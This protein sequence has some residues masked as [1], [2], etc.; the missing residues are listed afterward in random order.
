MKTLGKT[1]HYIH[2]VILKYS[3]QKQHFLALF[4]HFVLFKFILCILI[5]IFLFFIFNY[6]N[7]SRKLLYYEQFI[8]IIKT[9]FKPLN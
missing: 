3:T 8:S 5:N 6:Y 7:R 9:I 1:C 4:T 2:L